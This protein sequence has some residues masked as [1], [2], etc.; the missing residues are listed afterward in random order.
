MIEIPFGK[1]LVAVEYNIGR[2]TPRCDGCFFQ[3]L[4]CDGSGKFRCCH[5]IHCNNS[6]RKDGK[7]VIYK[8]VDYP[9]PATELLIDGAPLHNT[10]SGG[11]RK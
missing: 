1:A 10:Q 3:G 7:Y 9:Q 5:L 11:Y 8:L 6:E 4:D 2:F